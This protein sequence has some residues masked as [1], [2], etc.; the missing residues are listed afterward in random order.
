MKAKK[1]LIYT[2]T[3]ASICYHSLIFSQSFTRIENQAGLNRLYENMG[4]SVADYD[5][6]NDLDLL[7]VAKTKD[8]RGVGTSHSKLFENN[9]DGTYT[10]VTVRAGLSNLHPFD[11]GHLSDPENR[12][13]DSYVDYKWGASWGDYDNDG[14]P[15]LFFTNSYRVQLFNNLGNGSF[16]EVTVSAGFNAVNNCFNTSA[17][18]FDFNKDGYLDIFIGDYQSSCSGNSLYRNNGNGTFTDVSNLIGNE[19]GSR[20]SLF[21]FMAIPIDVNNDGW[22]D[23]YVS[24]DFGDN[25]LYINQNGTGFSEQSKAYNLAE[26]YYGM[27]VSVGDYNNDGLFDIYLSNIKTNLLYTK[28]IG[29]NY[30]DVAASQ[31]VT[32]GGWAWDSRFADFDLDYDEDL[33]LVNGYVDQKN[34]NVYFEN[35]LNEGKQEFLDQSDETNIKNLTYSIA[36]EVFD[37]D[38]DGDLDIFITNRDDKP[39]FYKNTVID[40]SQP[41][42]IHW[43]KVKLEGKTSNKDGIGASISITTNSGIYHRYYHGASLYG[44]SLQPVHFGISTDTEIE[45]I[46][47][48]WPSGQIDTYMNLSVDETILAVEGQGYQMLDIEPATVL[49]GCTDSTSCSYNPLAILDD[50]SCTYLEPKTITGNANSKFLKTETYTYPL[51]TEA[52]INWQVQGGEIIDGQGTSSVIIKWG[53]EQFGEVVAKEA[54]NVCSSL[55]VSLIVNLEE[56]LSFFDQ[57]FSVARLWNEALLNAIREDYARPTVHARNLFHA[58]IAM[59]DAWAVYDDNAKPYLT[60]KEVNSFKTVLKKFS[61]AEELNASRN[62]A[63][64]FAAYRLLSH[65]FQ[66][67]PNAKQ[68]KDRLDLLMNVLGYDIN[69]T[70]TD[71][72]TGDAAAMG[73]YIAEVIINYGLI[74]GSRESNAYDNAFYQPLNPPLAPEIAGNDT[75]IDPNRWQ[76][77]SLDVFIDQSGN[78]IAGD[79]PDFLNPEWGNV[80]SFSLTEDSKSIYQRNGNNYSVYHDPGTPPYLDLAMNTSASDAYKWGNSL[81]SIWSSH[82]DPTDNV[83]WDISP[84]AIGNIESSSLPRSFDDYST[85]YNLLEG[86]DIS[87][88][89]SI[90]PATNAPYQEQL[91]PRGDYTRVL[92]EFWADGPDSET[93]PG[94]W[95]AL[96]NYVND[97]P[98]LEKRLSGGGDVLNPLEWDVKSYFI[99]GGA[100][101]DAAI[102]AWSI[103]GWYDYV[104]PISAIRYMADKGQ[105]TDASIDN[106]DLAGIPLRPGFIEIVEEGDPLEGR[107]NENRGKIKLYTWKG[108]SSI[109]DTNVDQA[110]VG[111]I[112]AENWWPYQRPSFVTPPFAGFVSGHS[113]YSRAAAEVITLLTGD[114]YFPGGYGEFIAKKNEFLVFEEGPSMD[115]KL[116]WATYRDASDQCSLSRIWGGIHPPADDIPGR[117]IGEIVGVDAFYLA[118]SYF[119]GK[120]REV[121]DNEITIFPN[122]SSGNIFVSNTNEADTFILFDITGAKLEI[123]TEYNTLSKITTVKLPSSLSSGMYVIKVNNSSKFIIL[124]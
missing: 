117:L 28:D 123:S 122:P 96:L 41:D 112:L 86:G 93:P 72:A 97:N 76:P 22:L 59:Y 24:N 11:D 57:D 39:F 115:I 94:H 26:N 21:T 60:G 101:H 44:Q 23:I 43:F 12:V 10:D 29:D 77:L 35:L 75:D 19:A 65:R 5:G 15:D 80:F 62:K 113:T 27:G 90:N 30:I 70:S 116:Q 36:T 2:F 49:S 88:G 51:A 46:K 99:M 18:W 52:T 67:S 91:V 105:S 25:N 100:M 108:H 66:E 1:H 69:Y 106:Y 118:V 56:G 111:W 14:D 37:Y 82:L 109:G 8:E 4:V 84:N 124:K 73:N 50:N 33:L 79:T 40:G 120:E 7:V 85:F 47:I 6:D 13:D 107:E 87:K 31:K 3:I 95:F 38:N 61:P 64:S 9:N 78:L 71:Y 20:E 92:A 68:T 48:T 16:N 104:R 63:I 89:Y 54:D 53:V 45:E 121:D 102:S 74:D 34:F 119:Q 81:V 42:G 83:M 55:P 110:G 103:K 114:A 32:N 17:L 58:S 98:L